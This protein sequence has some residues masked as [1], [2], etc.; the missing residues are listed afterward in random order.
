MT[1][2]LFMKGKGFFIISNGESGFTIMLSQILCK[3][4]NSLRSFTLNG[5][6]YFHLLPAD[7]EGDII[8]PYTL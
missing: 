7:K 1:E 4:S 8:E 2:S 6:D 5:K 3:C